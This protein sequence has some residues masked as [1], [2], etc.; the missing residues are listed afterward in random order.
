LEMNAT[1]SSSEV[2]C[3]FFMLV[4]FTILSAQGRQ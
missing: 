3:G 2:R 4:A 1:E